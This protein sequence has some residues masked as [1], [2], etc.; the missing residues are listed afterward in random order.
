MTFWEV[1]KGKNSVMIPSFMV[2]CLTSLKR[3]VRMSFQNAQEESICCLKLS[4]LASL[5]SVRKTEIFLDK[6]RY[7]MHLR[8][9]RCAVRT[10]LESVRE[11]QC[12]SDK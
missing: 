3:P 2:P 8:T 4:T 12:H 5:V 1:I 9:L 6:F 10:L 11:A 7:Y